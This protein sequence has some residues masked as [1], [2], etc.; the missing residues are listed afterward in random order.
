MH[1]YL[2][3][4]LRTVALVAVLAV[5]AATPPVVAAAASASPPAPAGWRVVHY[6]GADFLA[7]LT[8][9][10]VRLDAD[11]T[12]CERLDVRAVYLGT[13]GPAARCS[14]A[15]AGRDDAIEVTRLEAAPHGLSA[16]LGPQHVVVAPSSS[17]ERSLR[18][19]FPRLGV[20]VRAP[21]GGL[22]VVRRVLGSFAM[23]ASAIAHPPALPRAPAPQ[24]AARVA[25]PA[26]GAGPLA[27]R[28]A[29]SWG[30]GSTRAPRPPSRRCGL[31]S[32]RPSAQWGSTWAAPTGRAPS[33]SSPRSGS[34]RWSP[35]GGTW[36]PSTSDCR[37]RAPGSAGWPRCAP[38]ARRRRE[39]PRPMTQCRRRVRS[40]WVSGPPSTSTWRATTSRARGACRPSTPSSMPGPRVCTGTATLPACTEDPPPRSRRSWR[41]RARRGSTSRTTSGSRIGTA[42]ARVFDDPYFTNGMWTEHQRVHQYLGGHTERWGGIAINIDSSQVDGAVVGRPADGSFVRTVGGG[43][44][45]IAGGAPMPVSDC[46][47]LGAAAP[48]RHWR[49]WPTSHG[50]RQT[51]PSCVRPV[52]GVSMSWRGARRSTSPIARRS[53][54]DVPRS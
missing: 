51:G 15:A 42:R 46:G 9:A 28:R 10:V 22:A 37:R 4:R 19:A 33:R 43:T 31:G 5:V 40:A 32:L 6:A 23:G 45:R 47:A 2:P 27:P 25:L 21:R 8:W 52:P 39:A 36:S 44:F 13:Q 16:R 29:L 14:G 3:R 41:H 24:P 11:P 35:W 34:P 26:D 7:P 48:S 54:R 1:P 49:R 30:A 17:I 18:I 38:I 12:A 50:I 20:Q 53:R